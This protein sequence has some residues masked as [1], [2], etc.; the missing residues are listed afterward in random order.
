MNESDTIHPA[1]YEPPENR[2]RRSTLRFRTG[3]VLTSLALLFAVAAVWFLLTGRAVYFDTTPAGA[4]IDISGGLQLKLADRYLLRPGEYRLRITAEGYHPLS[5]KL[6]V[7]DARNQ[8]YSYTLSRLPGHLAVTTEPAGA[9]VYIDG[10]RRGTTP[11]T[12]KDLPHGTYE[13]RLQAD[14]YLP[15]EGELELPGLD[16][17]RR[18]NVSLEP[19][20]AD[21]TVASEPAGAEVFVDDAAVGTTPL[22]A[23][24]LQGER[25]IRVKLEGYKAWQKTLQVRAGEPRTLTD[26]RLEP[27]D[28]V[29]HIFTAPAGAGVTVN[30][31]YLGTSPLEAAVEPDT[32]VNIRLFKQGYKRAARTLRLASGRERTLRI[33][34]QPELAAVEVRV[35]P[36]G[37]QLFV[38]GQPR[39]EANQTLSLPARE[40]RI[41]IRHQGYQPYQTR[42]TP[43][44]GIDQTIRVQLKTLREAKLEAMQP[45]IETAAGQR[46]KLLRPDTEF[47][48]GASRR[49]AGRRANETLRR[50]RL[51]R[52]FYLSVREVTNAEF[53]RFAAG[54]DSGEVDGKSLDKDNQP[55]VNVSWQQA[56]RYC[57]W[58][59]AKDDLT[60]FYREQEGAVTGV[61]PDADGYRLPTEAEWAWAARWQDGGS[62]LKFPWGGEMPPP[63]KSGN[64]A[65]ESAANLIGRIINGYNDGHA[66][67]APTGSFPASDKGLYDIGGNVAEWVNDFYDIMV[68]GSDTVRVDP[69]GPDRGDHHVIRGSSWAHGGITE[70]RL[71]YRD[72]GTDGRDDVGFRIAR[73]MLRGDL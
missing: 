16:Q 57:N 41:E 27:A 7:T 24:I 66:V 25:R 62:L 26:I 71:S 68:A 59:S 61:N 22:T 19:A 63:E 60:P 73:F 2:P 55:V 47:T 32:D 72:Y 35:E 65:D 6:T 69:L 28:A 37:A 17:T 46:M 50:V 36:A 31:R 10:E 54:H 49:E 51:S 58:L 11:V 43:R 40:H 64:Y 42:L 34:L 44:P 1:R 12:V 70:L 39:G 9:G 56:A 18:L 8:Q 29:V 23:Q 21:V 45:V 53:R 14:R 52:G 4:D 30:G 3:A 13:V 5:G 48:M 20:W 15:Y 38:D 33:D 67:T